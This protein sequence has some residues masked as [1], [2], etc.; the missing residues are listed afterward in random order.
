MMELV[1]PAQEGQTWSSRLGDFEA[2]LG[3]YLEIPLPYIPN[4]K[5]DALAEEA[6]LEWQTPDCQAKEVIKKLM[7][8]EIDSR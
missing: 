1:S 6:R 4:H 7:Y 2:A 3:R 5:L 8:R